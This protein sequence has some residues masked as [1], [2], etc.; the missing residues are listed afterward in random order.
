MGGGRGRRA[1]PRGVLSRRPAGRRIRKPRDG[2]PAPRGRPCRLHAGMERRTVG[3]HGGRGHEQLGRGGGRRRRHR[4]E[5]AGQRRPRRHLFRQHRRADTARRHIHFL[6]VR[7][8]QHGRHRLAQRGRTVSRLR[9]DGLRR[10]R[11]HAH[12]AR[13]RHTDEQ[14]PDHRDRR[15]HADR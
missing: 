9:H 6:F 10:K 1:L 5:G 2:E 13:G 3:P 4:G 15:G 14:Q 7:Q 11:K 12:A 8:H